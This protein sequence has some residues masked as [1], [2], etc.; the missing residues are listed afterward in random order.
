MTDLS[1]GVHKSIPSAR[2]HADDLCNEPTLSASVARTLIE[3][4]PAHARVKHPRLNEKF[5]AETKDHFD[6]GGAAHGVVL[7]QDNW[8]EEVEVV[9]ADSWRTKAAK[10]AR[11]KAYDEGRIPLLKDHYER[12]NE[13]VGALEA[14]DYT[15]KAFTQGT[16]EVT[17]IWRDEETGVL[18]RCRPDWMPDDPKDPWPD[19]KTTTDCRS[20]V[21]DRRFCMD[22]GGLLRAAFYEAG[23]KATCG[24]NNTYVQQYY[25][26]QEVAPPYS[27]MLKVMDQKSPLMD[28]A[29][30]MYR[31]ALN[32][33]AGCLADN[34]WPAY[35]LINSVQLREGLQ[36]HMEEKW[37]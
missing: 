26:V 28:I 25:V 37:L 29:R 19:Y 23:I 1:P 34:E 11:A 9:D 32:S 7:R 21:W 24:V 36:R 31:A 33:W 5:E 14:N 4:S 12:V 6:L 20:E 18:C 8:R 22:H 3:Q 15:A 17:L 35:G 27:A 10:K 13:M 2:Y 16:P 30:A